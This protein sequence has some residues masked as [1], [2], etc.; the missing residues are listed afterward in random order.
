MRK[1]FL[2]VACLMLVA[3]ATPAMAAWPDDPLVGNY[4]LY[5]TNPDTGATAIWAEIQEKVF[6]QQDTYDSTG[7]ANAYLYTYT[8][9]NDRFPSWGV[10]V[11][12]DGV[13]DYY[14][15]G[16]WCWGFMQDPSTWG[17][18]VLGW[19]GPPGWTPTEGSPGTFVQAGRVWT[20]TPYTCGC[21]G[22]GDAGWIAWDGT[23]MTEGIGGIPGASLNYFSLVATNPPHK[24][25]DAYVHGGNTMGECDGTYFAYGKISAPTPEP[26]SAVLL[27]L[28]LPAAAALRRRRED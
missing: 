2:G 19:T 11:D 24:M 22:G 15:G 16:I 9:T 18:N 17:A 8:V 5:Y 26:V 21:P 14:D 6:N 3:A 28:G 27:L 4:N 25:V 1:L 12:G 13:F 23:Q 20:T 10:D 7:F